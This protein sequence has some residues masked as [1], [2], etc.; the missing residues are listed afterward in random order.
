MILVWLKHKLSVAL[1]QSNARIISH[2]VGVTSGRLGQ[3]FVP[4]EFVPRIPF[5]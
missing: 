2:Y 3:R 4:G 5:Q 1:V